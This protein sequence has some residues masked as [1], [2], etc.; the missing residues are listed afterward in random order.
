MPRASALL[1]REVSIGDASLVLLPRPGARIS[2]VRVDNLEGFEGPPVFE[3][4]DVWMELAVLPL[5]LGRLQVKGIRAEGP[6]VHLAIDERGVSNFGDLLPRRREDQGDTQGAL[7]IALRRLRAS[8]ATVTYADAPESRALTLTGASLEADIGGAGSGGWRMETE[9]ASDSMRVVFSDPGRPPLH[10]SGP[11]AWATLYG[12]EV[13]DRIEIEEGVLA[14]DGQALTVGGRISGTRGEDAA[15]ELWLTHDALPAATLAHWMGR[16]PA[17][18]ATRISGLV[19][20]DAQL[21]APGPSSPS[22]VL[23]GEVGLDGV[24]VVHAG[25]SVAAGLTGT[26]EFAPDTLLMHAVAGT[27]A[28]GPFEL[29]GRVAGEDR[30]VRMEAWARPDLASFD[31]MDWTP[32]WARFAG[33]VTLDVVLS[34]S[35]LVP[36]R[37]DLTGTGIVAG[38]RMDHEQL[39]VPLY[40]PSGTVTF[41][42][43]D[44]FWTDVTLMAGTDPLQTTGRLNRIPL[45]VEVLVGALATPWSATLTGSRDRGDRRPVLEAALHGGSLRLDAVL[46]RARPRTDPTYAQVAFAHLGRRTVGGFGAG[47]AVRGRGMSRPGDLPVTGSVALDLDTLSLEPFTLT[48]LSTVLELS[49]GELVVREAAFDI[50]GGSGIADLSLSVGTAETEPFDLSL[51]LER[52]WA[53]DFFQ[54]LTPVGDAIDGVLDLDLALSGATE[55]TLLPA[56]EGLSGSGT[57][58]LGEG[59]VANTGVTYAVADFL[60]AEGWTEIPFDEWSADFTIQDN[61]IELTRSVLEGPRTDATLAGLIALEAGTDLSLGLSIPPDGL[62]G[63][64]LRRTGVGS[65]V[66]EGLRA[67]GEPLELGIRISGPLAGPTLEPDAQ[68]AVRPR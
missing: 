7:R 65:D 1:N 55:R 10:A 15:L 4:D 26:L 22:P 21:A 20:L 9:A 36:D 50:W 40:V 43:G 37:L 62:D 30:R 27:F 46:G 66:L 63:I 44:M 51:S 58:H 8:G 17:D 24:D 67:A 32:A 13:F 42:G 64:S 3:A 18:P 35:L 57:L 14:H 60:G 12:D 53:G 16:A 29:Y 28:G 68:A 54:T 23:R 59:R 33:N 48:G 25:E 6:R 41:Q 31:R 61:A 2:D 5:F 56:R 49:P 47:V 34:G 38:L 19:R 45:P 39:A 11:S 52:V